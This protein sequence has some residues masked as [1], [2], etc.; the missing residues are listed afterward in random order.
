MILSS[1]NKHNTSFFVTN[2]C[3]IAELKPLIAGGVGEKS[4]MIPDAAISRQ[5]I[6]PNLGC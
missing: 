1:I 4:S 6:L 2:P 5:R 3:S